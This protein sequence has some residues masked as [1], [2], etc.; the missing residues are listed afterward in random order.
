[1]SAEL[2]GNGINVNSKDLSSDRASMFR[3]RMHELAMC[4]FGCAQDGSD[5]R[6]LTDGCARA[7]GRGARIA[8]VHIG[9]ISKKNK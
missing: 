7:L 5:V 9:A 6:A 2:G 8:P 1:M 3:R 4:A